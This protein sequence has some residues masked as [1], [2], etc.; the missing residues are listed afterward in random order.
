MDERETGGGLPVGADLRGWLRRLADTGRLTTPRAGLDLRFEVAATANVLDGTAA[1]FFRGPGGSDTPVVSGLLSHRDWMAESMGVPTAEAARTF[2]EASEHPIDW[3]EVPDPACQQVIT[4]EVDLTTQLP[5]PT[6]NEHDSGA[7]ITAGLLIARN[8]VTGQQNVSI[9]RLQVTAPDKLGV[10]LLPRH[11]LAFLDESA[12]AGQALEIAVVIGVD[13][14]TLM[15]S[16]AIVPL[17]VDELTVSGALRGEPLPVTRCVTNEVRVP[18]DAEI[19][20]EGRIEAAE[21]A[22]E[23]P[24]GEFPQYYGERAERH[25]VTLDAMTTKEKPIF[26]TIVGGGLE[27]LLLG[28][29]PRE[30]T[31][32]VEL[33]RRFACVRDVHLSRGGTCRYH[34]YV[35]VSGH[36]PGEVTN[37]ILSA[38]SVHYDVKHVVVVDADVDVHDPMEVEWAVATR[39]QASRDLLVVDTAQG[40]KLD[41]ST[42]DGVGSKLGMDA[43]SPLDAPEM[44]FLRIR[45][46]GQE[47][48]TVD[49]IRAAADATS[50]VDYF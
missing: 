43:T 39:F 16:Q 13:P 6:H 25:V 21:R 2:G 36:K 24:F 40:S 19:V 22:P 20:L 41:P 30:A 9:H 44:K 27:H 42:V 32:L 17:G 34:L 48:L 50:P 29:L 12:A 11:T 8:P 35:Q 26:H 14:L 38:L 45:V 23:G 28:A 1:T 5:I 18:A 49:G 10:L 47:N 37:V 46:P 33:Q 7:Y 3:V 15:A 31:F 4:R